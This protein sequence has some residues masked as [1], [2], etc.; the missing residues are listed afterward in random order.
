M[1]SQIFF[2]ILATGITA[3]SFGYVGTETFEQYDSKGIYQGQTERKPYSNS[4]ESYDKNGIYQ[5]EIKPGYGKQTYDCYDK[6][7]IYQGSITKK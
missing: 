1:I 7:G 3:T 6:N 4:Y 2:C 5:G